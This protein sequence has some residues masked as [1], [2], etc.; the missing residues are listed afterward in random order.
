MISRG[1]RPTGD[2]WRLLRFTPRVPSRSRKRLP[3]L[4]FWTDPK[5]RIH[6]VYIPRDDGPMMRLLVQKPRKAAACYPAA[7]WLHGGG[8]A[9][10]MPEMIWM[11]QARTLGRTCLLVAPAYTLSGCRP[12]PAALDD[13]YLALL[14]LRDNAERLGAR[15]DQ[16]FVGGES[17]GGGLTA[18]LCL[19][20]RERGD[21]RIACQ[22]PLYPML[23][24]RMRTES[25]RHNDAPVW[26]AKQNAAGWAAYLRGVGEATKYAAPARE[27]NYA[28]LPP[29]ISFVGGIEP[30][31]DEAVQYM[32][33]LHSAGV[34]TRFRIFE[35]CFHAFDMMAPRSR[36]AKE[37]TAF[38]EGAVE[39]AERH[40]FA[41]QP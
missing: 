14:W 4:K 6:N 29:A 10:G 7:L 27:T 37:A 31:R 9:T 28:G 16:I 23:D 15:P 36:E 33:N 11:S 26:D 41:P 18:A 32:E 20:A 13:G 1:L 5:R 21:V 17:A 24:D 30:F 38:F 12:W 34:P 22:M 19:L 40:W 2:I 25:M 8:Y 35:G 39:H 3:A